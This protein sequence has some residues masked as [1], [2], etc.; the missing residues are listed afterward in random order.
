VSIVAV[1]DIRKRFGANEV[2]KGVS[3]TVE[4]GQVVALVGRSGS[5]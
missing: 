2:L 3:L 4:R 1:E 5:G